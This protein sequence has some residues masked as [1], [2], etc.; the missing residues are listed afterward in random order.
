MYDWLVSIGL[1]SN[2]S[3]RMGKLKIP[4]KYFIDFLRGHLDGDGSISTYT[5]YYNQYK[6]LSYVYK[7]IFTSFISASEKHI[8]WLRKEIINIINVNGALHKTKIYHSN[9]NPMYILKFAKKRIIEVIIKDI[10][11]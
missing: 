10:L 6:K 7:R 5:D 11:F 1:M 4:R 9:M 3:L 8:L 2:K